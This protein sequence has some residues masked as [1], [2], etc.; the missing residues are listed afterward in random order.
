MN[1]VS[2]PRV[3]DAAGAAQLIAEPADTDRDW[4][5]NLRA[6]TLVVDAD[7]GA[8]VLLVARWPGTADE[9]AAFRRAI[10]GYPMHSTLRAAGIR[11]KSRQFGYL[12]RQPILKRMACSL[13]A[14]A[15][16]APEEH[17]TI[18]NAAAMLHAAM[19]DTLPELAAEH[20]RI[21]DAEV[22]PDWRLPGSPWT[23]GVINLSSPLQYHYDTNNLTPIWSAMPVVRR[24]ARGGHLHIPEY[25][26][27]AECRDGDVL[28]FA[29]WQLV[30]GVTPITLTSGAGYRYSCVYYAVNNMR[31]C[32]PAGDELARAQRARTANE[33]TLLE[34]QRA[35]GMIDAGAELVPDE[36]DPS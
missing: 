4:S 18:V 28:W 1:T 16:E 26:A 32:L 21:A 17:D 27:I 15:L 6:D 13:C 22:L 24:H 7:T 29:G 11:N 30:H 20:R 25:D 2:L 36:L 10:L 8:P 34:R 14:G 35:L 3:L 9:L 19:A 12:A 23:S 31:H 5:P 33:D